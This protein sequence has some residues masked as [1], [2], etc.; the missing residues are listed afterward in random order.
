M[1]SRRLSGQRPKIRRY[2]S[3]INY[4][5]MW[6][7]HSTSY[8][9]IRL[10]NLLSVYNFKTRSPLIAC[11]IRGALPSKSEK[12]LTL[13][14]KKPKVW[15]LIMRR[16]NPMNDVRG[17]EETI[18][19]LFIFLSSSFSSI[20]ISYSPLTPSP[21]SRTQLSMAVYTILH[22]PVL[23]WKFLQAA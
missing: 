5:Q 12:A 14:R 13:E 8:S 19:F 20:V 1:H 2:S 3:Q 11:V 4:L 23:F 17:Q 18:P 9:H 6:R 10:L 7:L 16:K 21:R 15:L 22:Q